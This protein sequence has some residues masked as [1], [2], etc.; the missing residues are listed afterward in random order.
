MCLL[1]AL[2]CTVWVQLHGMQVTKPIATLERSNSTTEGLAHYLHRN[3]GR[4]P[5]SPPSSV[6]ISLPPAHGWHCRLHSTGFITQA[7]GALCDCCC[8]Y[9]PSAMLPSSYGLCAGCWPCHVHNGFPYRYQGVIGVG[10]PGG[11]KPTG[12]NES[13]FWVCFFFQAKNRQKHSEKN[14]FRFSGHNPAC[15]W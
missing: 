7:S 12:K 8:V 10:G 6:H 4:S 15:E 11:G 2:P 3:V 5:L 1:A 14:D 13:D 9:V